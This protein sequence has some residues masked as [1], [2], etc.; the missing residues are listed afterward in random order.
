ML[1]RF[2]ISSGRQGPGDEVPVMRSV[3]VEF[4]VRPGG[5]AQTRGTTMQPT[6]ERDDSGLLTH[7]PHAMAIPSAADRL[8]EETDQPARLE[9]LCAR[10]L[11]LAGGYGFSPQEVDQVVRQLSEN[12]S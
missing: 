9:A 10:F 11:S 6:P 7:R 8:A 1:I 12:G 5:A 4:A 2:G 3:A